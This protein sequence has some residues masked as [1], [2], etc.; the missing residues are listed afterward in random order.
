[1]KVSRSAPI[2]GPVLSGL[3]PS[4]AETVAAAIGCATRVESSLARAEPTDRSVN[5]LRFETVQPKF[6][7]DVGGTNEGHERGAE[8]PTMFKPLLALLALSTSTGIAHAETANTGRWILEV[9]PTGCV[10]HTASPSGTVV[11][12]W[13]IAGENDLSFLVQNKGWNSLADGQNYDIEVSF[14]NQRAFP[15]QATARLNLDSDGPGLTFGVSPDHR[16]GGVSFVEQFAGA[17]GMHITRDGRRIE[18]VS[19]ADARVAMQGLAQC[20]SQVWAEGGKG[21]SDGAAVQLSGD[22]KAI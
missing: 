16:A 5:S 10:V 9:A 17:Q 11:S 18:T 4:I 12:V 14:D 3:R 2:E 1:M 6:R 7:L 15:M 13:G 22:A 19:L 21:A 8:E 20:L